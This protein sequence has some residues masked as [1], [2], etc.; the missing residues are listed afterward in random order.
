MSILQEK[1]CDKEICIL[2]TA[3]K[4]KV[5]DDKK[6]WIEIGN[7]S[8]NELCRGIQQ[9]MKDGQQAKAMLDFVSIQYLNHM[10]SIDASEEK[11]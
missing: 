5:L 2:S 4:I 7:L 1:I 9:L 3:K 6:G 10:A 11:K 8:K